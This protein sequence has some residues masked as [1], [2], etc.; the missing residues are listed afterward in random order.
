VQLER[1]GFCEAGTA[2]RLERDGYWDVD[3]GAVAVNPSGGTLCTN[4]I[5]VTGLVRAI[6]AAS[7]VMGTA[8]TMQVQRAVRNAVST[9]IGGIAQFFN[10]TVFG[11]EPR[12]SDGE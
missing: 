3:G 12:R 7:Q 4:A 1:L 11:D 2:L 10:C 5:A 8:G 6:D 9:A